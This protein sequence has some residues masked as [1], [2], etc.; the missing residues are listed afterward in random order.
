MHTAR[1]AAGVAVAAGA[2]AF[3]V[4]PANASGGTA[5]SFTVNTQF[6]AAPSNIVAASGPLA[7]CSQVTD[8]ANLTDL[9]THNQLVFSG[10]KQL[11]CGTASVTVGY[12]AFI[13]IPALQNPNV[14]PRGGAFTTHGD[15][16][17][18]SSTLAGVTSGGGKLE[19]DN[20]TCIPDA[21]SNGCVTDTFRGVVS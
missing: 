4:L 14:L 21:D 12:Q 15:W 2:A 6:R 19:G 3:S 18:I 17:V 10:V 20:R 5:T 11:T 1:I 8:L 13:S 16:W 9:R 7:A